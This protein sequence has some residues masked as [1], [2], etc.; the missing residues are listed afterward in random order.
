MFFQTDFAG[1]SDFTPVSVEAAYK[2]W[3]VSAQGYVSAFVL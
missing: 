2:M 1:S 3:H